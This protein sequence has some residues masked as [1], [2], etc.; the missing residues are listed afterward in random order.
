MITPVTIIRKSI[1][2]Y[3]IYYRI[4]QKGS[5]FNKN[6]KEKERITNYL[7]AR[8][9]IGNEIIIDKPDLNLV[10]MIQKMEKGNKKKFGEDDTSNQSD[11]IKISSVLKAP[12]KNKIPMRSPMKTPKR[13]SLGN[14]RPSLGNPRP[15][16]GNAKPSGFNPANKRG[17][18]LNIPSPLKRMSLLGSPVKRNSENVFGKQKR[19]SINSPMKILFKSPSPL[20]KRK[21]T[22]LDVD[23]ENLKLDSNF[24]LVN[25]PPMFKNFGFKS[26]KSGKISNNNGSSNNGNGTSNAN[27]NTGIDGILEISEN[28]SENFQVVDNSILEI[29]KSINMK[30]KD[31]DL[32]SDVINPHKVKK[33]HK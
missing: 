9:T 10:Q 12:F 4:H 1:S 11:I 7:D 27:G 31:F 5:V 26:Q 14:P 8:K 22:A 18:I 6:E 17:S 30:Y 2:I 21:K 33:D 15:S 25:N 16:F 28:L 20:K 3:Y 24:K 19:K 13:P 32:D 23:F 29:D